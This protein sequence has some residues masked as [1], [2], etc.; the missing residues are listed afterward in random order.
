MMKTRD[1]EIDR[2][3]LLREQAAQA[4]AAGQA[5]VGHDTP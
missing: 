1:D 4:E 2:N 3:A 5:D